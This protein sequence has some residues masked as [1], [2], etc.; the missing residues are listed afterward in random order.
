MLNKLESV[1][2]LFIEFSKVYNSIGIEYIQRGQSIMSNIDT[3]IT[4]EE[5]INS[6][7]SYHLNRFL[8]SYE[9]EQL[10]NKNENNY[11]ALSDE[12]KV[13]YCIMKN[14]FLQ[15]DITDDEKINNS[16]LNF[17]D[18]GNLFFK[19]SNLVECSKI[20]NIHSN[21]TI[22][23]LIQELINVELLD[24]ENIQG[25]EAK[26]YYL[27]KPKQ[28]S[29]YL[30]INEGASFLLPYFLFD[31]SYF[32]QL[33]LKSKIA[34]S[35]LL[36][37]YIGDFA[38]T[39]S[40]DENGLIYHNSDVENLKDMLGFQSE[41]EITKIKQ[42]LIETDLLSEEILDKRPNR[43]YLNKPILKS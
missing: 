5:F 23:L 2:L 35:I 3:S 10:L 13:L 17:D 25:Q 12:A 15:T 4:E 1:V 39:S 18:E 22:E 20:L 42:E 43:L 26:C 31:F 34:Y 24:E 21:N 11:V 30:T 36:E 28:T 19:Y 8:F 7:N 40:I 37:F 41:A 16:N 32:N 9:T 6:S 29:K 14:A 33:S 38:N 27:K